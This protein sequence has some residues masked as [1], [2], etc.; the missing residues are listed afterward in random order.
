MFS[1]NLYIV[2]FSSQ[3]SP[4]IYSM[5]CIKYTKF[6]TFFKFIFQTKKKYYSTEIK[7]FFV[8]YFLI[9]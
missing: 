1:A 8:V 2:S 6:Y 9:E 7:V 4:V 5:N 3:L